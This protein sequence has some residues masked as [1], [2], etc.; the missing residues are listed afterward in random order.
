MHAVQA[1]VT[2]VAEMHNI[3]T[4]SGSGVPIDLHQRISAELAHRVD[5][6]IEQIMAEFSS[7]PS[8]DPRSENKAEAYKMVEEVVD[9]ALDRVEDALV[10]IYASLGIPASEAR[11]MSGNVRPHIKHV[12]LAL[13][14]LCSSHSVEK[15]LNSRSLIRIDKLADEHPVVVGTVLT[16]A[17]TMLLPESFILR[18]IMHIFGWGTRGPVKGIVVCF[19]L[20]YYR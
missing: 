7:K 5:G 16:A 10:A 6:I 19:L 3:I 13:C 20:G 12:V 8:L 2:S 18:P 4:N 1:M 17:V 11:A 9:F 15:P 14:E